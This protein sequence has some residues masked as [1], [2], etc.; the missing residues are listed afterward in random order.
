MSE[1]KQKLLSMVNE[2][3]DEQCKKMIRHIED[4]HEDENMTPE[5][6][7]RQMQEAFNAIA[8]LIHK[9]MQQAKAGR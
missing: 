7:N 4:L 6:S 9:E 8:M 5:E 1:V 3:N 2:L